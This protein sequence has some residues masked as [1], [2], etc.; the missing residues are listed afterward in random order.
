MVCWLVLCCHLNTNAPNLS[1]WSIPFDPSTSFRSRLLLLVQNLNGHKV[2]QTRIMI[3]SWTLGAIN[4]L[5]Q[6][7]FV[8]LAL[9]ITPVRSFA[10]LPLGLHEPR[11]PQN[12]TFTR[13]WKLQHQSKARQLEIM[14]A[15]PHACF[16]IR[17]NTVSSRPLINVTF[18][19][20]F[21]HPTSAC[22]E[23][24]ASPGRW[25]SEIYAYLA[26]N[27]L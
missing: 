17:G 5:E 16:R 25:L 10:T 22:T 14:A 2:V 4:D 13:G 20:W 24:A 26:F 18:I 9:L 1:F 8:I 12:A 23:E 27:I 6:G 19:Y 11:I 3:T 7:H 15:K 21:C